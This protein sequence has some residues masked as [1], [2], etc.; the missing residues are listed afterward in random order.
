[1]KLTKA[2]YQRDDVLMVAQELLGKFLFSAIDNKLTGGMI[3]ETE[4]YQGVTDRAC[5]AYG[6][7]RTKRTETMYQEGGICYVYLC[8]GIHSLLNVVTHGLGHPHAVLIRA[9]KPT[10]G[11]AYMYERRKK[12]HTETLLTSGPGSLTQA[13]GITTQHN[14]VSL[15]SSLIWIENREIVVAPHEIIKGPRIGVDYAGE[16]ALLPWRFRIRK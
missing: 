14:G 4:A 7:R 1:M 6:D 3:I 5:H 9:L 11:I 8:Y 2:F 10:E 15:E 13:L 12:I 16:D